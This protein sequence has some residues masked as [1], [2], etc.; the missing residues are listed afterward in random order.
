V[1]F[2]LTAE[3]QNTYATVIEIPEAANHRF[4]ALDFRVHPSATTLVIPF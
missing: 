1:K 2:G 3:K 4:D